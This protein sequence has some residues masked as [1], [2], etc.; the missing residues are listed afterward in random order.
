MHHAAMRSMHS[1]CS[2][3]DRALHAHAAEGGLQPFQA[4]AWFVK[5][6]DV[7]GSYQ[8]SERVTGNSAFCLLLLLP[9]PA[10]SQ[11]V[12][13]LSTH[14]PSEQ[15]ARLPRERGQTKKK[16]AIRQYVWAYG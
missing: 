6:S 15:E 3:R 12:V 10:E 14:Q 2:T 8:K 9:V 1:M 11:F 16:K 13:T 4:H 5:I 7:P